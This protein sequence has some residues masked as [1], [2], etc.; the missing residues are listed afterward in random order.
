[1]QTLSRFD[2]TMD[3]VKWTRKAKP[4]KAELIKMM[5]AEGHACALYSDTPGTKYARHKHDFDDFLV[6]VSGQMKI[7]TDRFE[8]LMKPGDR[9]DIPANTVHW[10]NMVGK[11]EVHYLSAAK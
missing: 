5:E 9:L 11:E 3:V 2:K 1:M 6:I 8:W 10:A 7:G 4:T